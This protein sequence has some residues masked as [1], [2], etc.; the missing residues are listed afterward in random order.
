MIYDD[1][2]GKFDYNNNYSILKM[3]ADNIKIKNWQKI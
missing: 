3:Y 1:N 2:N